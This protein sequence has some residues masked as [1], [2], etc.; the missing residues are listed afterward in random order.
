MAKTIRSL[1]AGAFAALA[2]TLAVVVPQTPAHANDTWGAGQYV[3]GHDYYH[4]QFAGEWLRR[5]HTAPCTASTSDIDSAASAMPFVWWENI[6]SSF[7]TFANCRAKHF[8]NTQFGGAAV[9]GTGFSTGMSYIGSALDDR[10]SSIQW[11]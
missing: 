11:T 10:T 5:L 6:I 9:P 8:E 3:I 7:D 1:V 4:Q 2:V